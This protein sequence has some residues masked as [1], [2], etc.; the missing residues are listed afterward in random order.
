MAQTDLD[1]QSGFRWIRGSSHEA[2]YPIYSGPGKAFGGGSIM[3]RL[4]FEFQN[5]RLGVPGQWSDEQHIVTM[6][7]PFVIP[8]LAVLPFLWVRER[9]QLVRRKRLNLCLRCGYDLRA[10]KIR[11]PECGEA[12]PCDEQDGLRGGGRAHKPRMYCRACSYILDAIPDNRCPKCGRLFDPTKRRT[13]A[14][15]P[16]WRRRLRLA[17]VLGL[18]LILGAMA[19]RIGRATSNWASQRRAVAEI[20]ATKA[21]V[22]ITTRS[23]GPLLFWLVLGD[24]FLPVVT[25]VNI[26]NG[27]LNEQ[28]L[29][30]FSRL[31]DLESLTLQYVDVTDTVLEHI[32]DLKKLRMLWT[33]ETTI[34]D[35][36]MPYLQQLTNLETLSLQGCQV[37]DNGLRYLAGL[38]Q[39]KE[40]NIN[41]SM[42]TDQGLECLKALPK[43]ERLSVSSP[44]IT[45]WHRKLEEGES[46]PGNPEP[47]RS[48]EVSPQ[49][50]CRP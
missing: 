42:I 47:R 29:A 6:P 28:S 3:E 33:L 27:S 45:A 4:G 21:N 20:K 22:S 14:R 5:F 24:N 43:L 41:S 25:G 16:R 1:P 10:S 17:L 46:R 9:R 15:K 36:G 40:L 7:Y 31:P 50:A 39:L 26:H 8:I 2:E 12:I 19:P 23:Q 37:T 34:G 18:L 13:Y 38:T 32:K 35:Q 30:A 11:C 49:G 48:F 44:L